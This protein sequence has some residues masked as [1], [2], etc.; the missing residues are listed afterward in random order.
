MQEEFTIHDVSC[1]EVL[2]IACTAEHHVSHMLMC[3]SCCVS[4]SSCGAYTAFIWTLQLS[5]HN[6][7]M[8]PQNGIFAC[9]GSAQLIEDVA[10]VA[11]AA[12]K[13]HEDN[14]C[15]LVDSG[16]ATQLVEGLR[17]E[18]VSQSSSAVQAVCAC[19]KSLTTADDPKPA[20]SRYIC[21]VCPCTQ[22]FAYLSGCNT[23]SAGAASAFACKPPC[24]PVP[25]ACL[26]WLAVF[27]TCL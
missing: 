4:L 26:S 13:K 21:P 18:E 5:N 7:Q 11:E 23:V 6:V 9:S 12:A 24:L 19:L 10:L 22:F 1:Y 3:L 8:V 25:V 16:C 20:A 14:K 27:Q 17:I 2:L 15:S